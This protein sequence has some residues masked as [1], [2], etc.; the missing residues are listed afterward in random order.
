[1]YIYMQYMS[2]VP[3]ICLIS[4]TFRSSCCITGSYVWSKWLHTCQHVLLGSNPVPG[5]CCKNVLTHC[6][7]VC[8]VSIISSCAEPRMVKHGDI[9][10]LHGSR[11]IPWYYNAAA[12]TYS[13]HGS[14][15]SVSAVWCNT[16]IVSEERAGEGNTKSLSVHGTFLMWCYL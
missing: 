13:V 14:I 1:M 11:S 12:N 4:D 9:K 7:A 6:L 5:K 8:L 15:S 16:Q 10:F 3:F 2:N